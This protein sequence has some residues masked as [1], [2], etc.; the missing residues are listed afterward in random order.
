MLAEEVFFH[1]GRTRTEVLNV[2]EI[3]VEEFWRSGEETAVK[4]LR[5]G[6]LKKTRGSIEAKEISSQLVGVWR[7][8]WMLGRG[9]SN[10]DGKN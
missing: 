7:R 2:C 5:D 8:I 6:I 4:R 10:E 3:I 1:A 9:S